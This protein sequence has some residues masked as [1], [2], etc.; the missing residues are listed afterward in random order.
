M[1]FLGLVLGI[2]GYY[3]FTYYR[4]NQPL[5]PSPGSPLEEIRD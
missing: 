1:I 4:R 5:Y 2:A 3:G